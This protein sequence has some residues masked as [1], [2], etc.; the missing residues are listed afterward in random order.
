MSR[1]RNIYKLMKYRCSQP[2]YDKYKYYGGRGIEVCSDWAD[3]FNSFEQWAL[4]NGYAEGLTLDR[5]DNDGDYEPENCRWVT[6]KEQANNRSTN[7]MLTYNGKTQ[8]I[9]KWSEELDISSTMLEQRIKAG[10]D[11]EKALTEPNKG[12]NHESLVTYEGRTQRIF[13]WAKELGMKRNTLTSRIIQHK[14]PI[15]KALTTPVKKKENN[16]V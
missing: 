15:E 2:K 9:Q 11:V 12:T 1:L 10:W 8:S 14:W 6:L 3:S 16:N 4:E 13:E 7:H 5:I